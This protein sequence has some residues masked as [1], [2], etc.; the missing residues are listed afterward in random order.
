MDETKIIMDRTFIKISLLEW[1]LLAFGFVTIS[2]D[3]VLTIQWGHYTIRAGFLALGAVGVIRY[4]KSFALRIPLPLNNPFGNYI[5]LFIMLLSLSPFYGANLEKS[6]GYLTY[7]VFFIFLFYFPF[8]LTIRERSVGIKALR[9]CFL[10]LLLADSFGILQFVYGT[11]TGNALLVR[12][13]AGPFPRIQGFSYEPSYFAMYNMV[14]FHLLVTLYIQGTQLFGKRYLLGLIILSVLAIILSTS[15]S[16]WAILSIVAGFYLMKYVIR[17]RKIEYRRLWQL[18]MVTTLI[19]MII[20]GIFPKQV[21]R[22]QAVVSKLVGMA[23]NI[24]EPSST[25][26]RIERIFKA[27]KTF[28]ENPAIGVGLGGFGA[29]A[30]ERFKLPGEPYYIVTSNLWAEVLAE[31]GIVGFLIFLCMIIRYVKEL[32]AR[33]RLVK[34]RELSLILQG[35]CSS[36]IVTFFL[37]YQFNQTLYRGYVWLLL[38]LGAIFWRLSFAKDNA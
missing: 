28:A 11:L 16:G 19:I 25:Q 36:T 32:W 12:G 14:F 3:T 37:S 26:P 35:I 10:G 8:Q 6:I 38:T 27:V 33:A 24:H 22:F 20:V 31:L 17:R 7:A 5:F 4:L 1:A 15:R 13:W 9:F 18:A 30:K 23:V 2:W 21:G 34:D 29:Y